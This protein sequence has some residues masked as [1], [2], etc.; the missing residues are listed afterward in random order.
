MLQICG[1]LDVG[2]DD[3]GGGLFEKHDGTWDAG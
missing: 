3:G 1:I 2:F